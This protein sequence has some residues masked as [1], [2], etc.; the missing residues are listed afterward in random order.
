MCPSSSCK[1]E[2]LVILMFR[3]H[4]KCFIIVIVLGLIEHGLTIE[5]HFLDVGL[6]IL[7]T[8]EVRF[9]RH[10]YAQD[11]GIEGVFLF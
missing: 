9:I 7:N 8:L 11:W 4:N 3:T 1:S 5:G 6:D 2:G 10:A